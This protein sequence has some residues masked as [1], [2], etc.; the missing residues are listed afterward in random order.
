MILLHES[1]VSEKLELFFLKSV[2]M[3][4]K[5]VSISVMKCDQVFLT[6]FALFIFFICIYHI[7]F[8]YLFLC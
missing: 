7:Y 2:T 3:A 5:R 8:F 6:K 1:F 4:Q